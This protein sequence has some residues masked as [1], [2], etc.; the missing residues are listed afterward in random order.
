MLLVNEFVPIFPNLIQ[1]VKSCES[2][3]YPVEHLFIWYKPVHEM[4]WNHKNKL[5]ILAT[6]FSFFLI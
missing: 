5:D 4:I 3:A 2:A 6:S 1:C